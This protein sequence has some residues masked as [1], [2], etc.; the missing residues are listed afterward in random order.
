[1]KKCF[2]MQYL[3]HIKK[4]LFKMTKSLYIQRNNIVN[5]L[6]M[7][8]ENLLEIQDIKIAKFSDRLVVNM[9]SLMFILLYSK[10]IRF[11]KMASSIQISTC[12]TLTFNLIII[13]I[14]LNYTIENLVLKYLFSQLI[15]LLHDKCTSIA[16]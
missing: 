5:I 14:F 15:S 10:A 12:K 9:H 4:P 3:N 13:Y 1:M 7:K 2:R 11:L 16:Y 8:H 6:S